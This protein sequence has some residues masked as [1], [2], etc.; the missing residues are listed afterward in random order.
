MILHRGEEALPRYRLAAS[1]GHG[2][3]REEAKRMVK[4]WRPGT[5]SILLQHRATRRRC[6]AIAPSAARLMTKSCVPVRC[7]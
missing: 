5:G 3:M 6:V 7:C 2:R 1:A 4:N